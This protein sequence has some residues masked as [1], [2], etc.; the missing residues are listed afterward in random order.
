MTTTAL[1]DTSVSLSVVYPIVSSAGSQIS[2][3][4]FYPQDPINP[5]H[6]ADIRILSD[7]TRRAVKC[8]LEAKYN[9]TKAQEKRLCMPGEDDASRP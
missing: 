5:S 1:G 8:Q 7:D 3:E 2:C 6:V 4:V 9:N